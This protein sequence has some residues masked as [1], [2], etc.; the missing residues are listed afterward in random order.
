MAETNN[1]TAS[2]TPSCSSKLWRSHS[3]TPIN[4]SYQLRNTIPSAIYTSSNNWHSKWVQHASR[5]QWLRDRYGH[6]NTDN[7]RIHSVGKQ[8]QLGNND[9]TKHGIRIASP[10]LLQPVSLKSLPWKH[11]HLLCRSNDRRSRN[12]RKYG[13]YSNGTV[14]TLLHRA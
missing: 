10:I 11:N 1:L 13:A 3:S 12:T 14:H 5:I 2:R 9:S 4:R 7:T 8:S 6:N